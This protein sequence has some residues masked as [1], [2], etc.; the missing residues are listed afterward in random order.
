M[1]YFV[2]DDE[3]IYLKPNSISHEVCD[4]LIDLFES[5]EPGVVKTGTVVGGFLPEIKKT[6]D[7]KLNPSINKFDQTLY[8]EISL[9]LNS[10]FEGSKHKKVAPLLKNISDNGYHIQKYESNSGYYN[11]HEDEM[12]EYTGNTVKKRV[13]TFIWYLNTVEQ[14]GETEFFNGRIKIKPEKGKLLVFPSTWTYMHKGNIPVSNDKYIVTGWVW[15]DIL[16]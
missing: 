15:S 6:F 12:I 13:L 11:Y 1:S 8:H 16:P 7:M 14:G 9:T 10:Y 3:Y 4:F 5:A 2:D